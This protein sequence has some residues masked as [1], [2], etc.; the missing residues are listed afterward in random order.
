MSPGSFQ[1][2]SVVGYQ[3]RWDV[4]RRECEV[5]NT[6]FVL[7]SLS[8]SFCVYSLF[9]KMFFVLCYS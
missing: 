5:M 4:S 2:M 3:N 8:L 7:L 9:L 1:A 6:G